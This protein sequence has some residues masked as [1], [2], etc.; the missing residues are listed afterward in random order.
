MCEGVSLLIGP[1]QLSAI[2]LCTY[3]WHLM[4]LRLRDSNLPISQN[5]ERSK[6]ID[7]KILPP[8]PSYLHHLMYYVVII[9]Y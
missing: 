5:A 8:L 2:V 3:V 6:Y 4:C 1:V 7:T 9:F